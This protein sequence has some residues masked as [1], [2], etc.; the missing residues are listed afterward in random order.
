MPSC[1]VLTGLYSNYPGGVA[2]RE[3]EIG[4][5]VNLVHVY[6]VTFTDAFPTAADLA[7]LGHGTALFV[8]WDTYRGGGSI[9]IP[10]SQIASGAWDTTID[11]E[12]ARLRSYG[13]PIMVTLMH[14]MELV[15]RNGAFGMPADFTT[16]WRHVVTRMRADGATNVIWV[17]DMGGE[18]AANVAPVYYP[19]GDVV[20]WV[21]WDPYNW[22][23]CPRYPVGWRSF[24][25]I[26][27]QNYRYFTTTAPYSTKPLMLAEFGTVEQTNNPL[28]K[29]QWLQGVG[30][31]A[32][33]APN[34]KALVYFDSTGVCNWAVDSTPPALV[35]FV[36]MTASG[37]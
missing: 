7:Q 34:I 10:W 15:N 37:Y 1:G 11:A 21:A 32:A 16:M 8:D 26:I 18:N 22:G 17:W 33:V 27:G 35:G 28:G 2:A 9:P 24:S 14:E 31:Q 3:A 13:Q 36:A 30:A 12:A 20:D 19:G 6:K 25:Q 23:N 5:S 29:E 4:R